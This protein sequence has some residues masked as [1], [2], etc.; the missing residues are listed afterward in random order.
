ML[1]PIVPQVAVH[2]AVALAVNC[3]VPLIATEGFKG[4]IVN[5]E[6]PVPESATC[7]GLFVAESVKLS[8]AVRAPAAVGLN[9]IVAVQPADAVRLVPHVLLE[10]VKSVAFAPVIA[11]LLMVMDAAVALDKVAVCD[12]VLEPIVVL[13][14]VR[15]AGVAATVPGAAPVPESARV[16]GLLLAASAKFK[17]AVRSPVAVGENTIVTVQLADAARLVP[18]VLLKIW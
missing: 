12:A 18:H 4:E 8:V 11:T 9:T 6:V 16:W 17:V 15:L 7:C 2:V 1:L 10:T 13:A 3:N 5:P 14:N